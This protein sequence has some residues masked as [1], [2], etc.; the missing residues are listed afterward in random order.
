MK[1]K[2]LLAILVSVA[3][4]TSFLPI[5]A[6][7]ELQEPPYEELKSVLRSVLSER[8]QLA[9]ETITLDDGTVLPKDMY[10]AIAARGGK[11]P[12]VVELNVAPYTTRQGDWRAFKAQAESAHA[13][14]YGQMKTSVPSAVKKHDLYTALN[15]FTAEVSLKDLK[16]AVGQSGVGL[17]KAVYVAGWHQ[18]D[19]LPEPAD[20]EGTLPDMVNSAPLI[21][22][23]EAWAS[24]YTGEGQYV[25]VIDTGIDYTHENFGGYNNFPNDKV[26]Y[27]YDFYYRDNDPM[28]HFGHGTHVAGTVAGIGAAYYPNKNGVLTPVKGVA[29]DAK[30]VAAKVFSDNEEEDPYAWEDDIVAA[31]DWIAYIKAVQG[32]NIAAA[33]MSLGARKGFD[34]PEDPEQAAIKR[35]YEVGITFAI[36]AGN[37]AYFDY[38]VLF[39]AGDYYTTYV[40]DVAQVGSP[41]TSRYAITVAAVNN[42]GAVIRGEQLTYGT[43]SVLYLA[44]PEAPHPVDVFGSSPVMLVD[45][46]GQL[47][48]PNGADYSNK[49]VLID[50]GTCSFADKVNNARS[51]GAVGIIVGNYD[52]DV[53]LV[54][55]ALGTAARTIPAVFVNGPHKLKLRAAI[56]TAGGSL[57]ATFTR[58]IGID[59]GATNSASIATFTSWGPAPN[60][61]F[62]PTVAA[63]GV[64][65]WSSVPGNAYA[66]YQGTSMA[67]PHVAGAVALIKQ[68]HPDW[69]PEQIKQALV[70]T[71]E[72]LGT[73][74]PRVQGAGRI[75]VAKA[76]ANSVF[77]TYNAQPYAELGVFSSP[78]AIT[79]TITNQGSSAFTAAL[80]GYL[81]VTDAQYA[82][83]NAGRMFAGG[84]VSVPSAVT[85][86]AHS[87]ATIAVVVQPASYWKNVFIDGRV[88]FTSADFTRVFPLM[89]YYGD[90]SLYS[91]A[92][93]LEG[94][95]RYPFNNNLIDLPYWNYDS[96][97][98]VTGLY[99]YDGEDFYYIAKAMFDKY[100]YAYVFDR[101]S[102]AISPHS[103][104]SVF[105]DHAWVALNLLRNAE[106]LT[107]KVYDAK[108]K[109]VKTLAQEQFV[110]G[111]PLGSAL[112]GWDQPWM[113]D[114]TNQQGGRV[115][116]G[117]YTL[118][119]E[120]NPGT[121]ITDPTP[122]PSQV[123]YIPVMVDRKPPQSGIT[124]DAAVPFGNAIV[125]TASRVTLTLTGT[126]ESTVLG[127]YL[128][129]SGK[130]AD[131]GFDDW[132]TTA[133]TLSIASLG[134]YADG[135]KLPMQA[136]AVD[137]AGNAAL[138]TTYL[139]YDNPTSTVAVDKFKAEYKGGT[140]EVSG[141][142][143][144][145]PGA[146]YTI[147]I[148][149]ASLGVV[150]TA[151]GIA[152][153][154]SYSISHRYALPKGNYTAIIDATD[155]YGR[156]V[157]LEVI[158]KQ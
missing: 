48:A 147:T 86:P 36:S 6:I 69:M 23:Y 149:E 10:E 40:K 3:L 104:S 58:E 144:Y 37:N 15:G 98:L 140:V 95:S 83:Y 117:L 120:A 139:V 8:S 133:T 7:A 4:L 103:R 93:T 47:C 34:Y 39:N 121:V 137:G 14:A 55:M 70:N 141:K 125:P 60:L 146:A 5:D 73:Y 50:R 100:G 46:G 78:K 49:V 129:W 62:K 136:V 42:Q 122:Q 94:D 51:Q 61:A 44:S 97:N 116:D 26:P 38:S 29:P 25:A 41:G 130:W 9:V 59:Y 79:L 119:I 134:S 85:V 33:N 74:S 142:I 19:D 157:H 17:I 114:G 32:V 67:A 57:E 92:D 153:S 112:V 127:Y 75:N 72:P 106:T 113:W 71:A 96:W 109:L 154:D 89:G 24:G 20:G 77:I 43:D 88:V 128:M 84:T 76:I 99:W 16:S 65:V 118:V 66:S 87:S 132:N 108:G 151:T 145:A 115:P 64:D 152:T 105:N 2:K 22:A 131:A 135:V 155:I 45:A 148:M 11:V 18:L 27:G 90:W 81:R 21:G 124:L 12:I 80:S 54:S 53:S 56:Q 35:A 31:I 1:P 107:V 82:Y 63:P 30:L 123:M 126:D 68:A 101:R 138:T 111:T 91:D 150:A 52:S 28:D 110:R 13:L 143:L 158:V 156:A 102:L